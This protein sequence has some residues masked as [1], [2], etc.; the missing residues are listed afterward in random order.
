MDWRQHYANLTT[1]CSAENHCKCAAA[2]RHILRQK[3]TKFS[4]GC[5]PAHTPLTELSP[6]LL[7]GVGASCP[8]P[9]ISPHKFGPATLI[10]IRF[11]LHLQLQ[12]TIAHLTLCVCVQHVNFTH[13]NNAQFQLTVEHTSTESLSVQPFL[14]MNHWLISHTTQTQ[15]TSIVG[16]RY[17]SIVMVHAITVLCWK[18]IHHHMHR[19]SRYSMSS[20][21]HV[22]CRH[23][24]A[25]LLCFVVIACR[26]THP[27]FNYRQL[28]FPVAA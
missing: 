3:F 17:E 10:R 16:I 24:S 6:D 22:M 11:L 8:S 2:W 13:I 19:K 7:A 27:A 1:I 21:L 28:S 5:D 20:K 26:P 23:P 4:L 18:Q 15:E 25:S 12:W 9:K 14:I